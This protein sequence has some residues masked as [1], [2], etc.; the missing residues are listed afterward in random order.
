MIRKAPF[1]KDAK[2]HPYKSIRL[3]NPIDIF[4][5]YHSVHSNVPNKN[6][7]ILDTMHQQTLSISHAV[8]M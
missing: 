5:C 6:L 1:W 8:G 2:T 4:G 3:D 7:L